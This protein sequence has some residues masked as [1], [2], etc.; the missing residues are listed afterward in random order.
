[1]ALTVLEPTAALLVIDLQ[2]GH[3]DIPTVHPMSEIIAHA[4]QLAD[5]VRAH[6]LPVVHVTV[7]GRAPGR[8]D[9]SAPP[10]TPSVLG[11]D[12]LLAEMRPADG[13]EVVR[14]ARWGAFTGTNLHE[15]LQRRGVTQVV[16]T[17]VATSMG[18]ESTARA[19]HEL[20]YHVV[21]VADAVTDPD[22]DAHQNSLTRVFP[23]IAETT[24][25]AEVLAML[26]SAAEPV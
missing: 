24:T 5:A 23:K 6:H 10:A 19:A 21:V 3:R 7:D 18:I 15:T 20:G 26:A 13:E 25:T 4:A 8:T 17:G 9:L 22:A 2:A 1:M 16:L 11:S 12:E 14:K